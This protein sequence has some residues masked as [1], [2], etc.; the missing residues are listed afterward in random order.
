MDGRAFLSDQGQIA[1]QQ[2]QNAH[3]QSSV[4]DLQNKYNSAQAQNT[5]LQSSMNDLQ[6]QFSSVLAE[7][8][9]LKTIQAECCGSVGS[10]STTGS[11]NLANGSNSDRPSLAQNVPNP[12]TQN[13]IISYYLPASIP[14]A[15]ITIRSMTGTSLQTFNISSAGHGQITVSQGTLAP[16]TYEYDM[17]VN[18]KLIDSK[19]MV[20]IGQ[21]ISSG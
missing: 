16:A 2:T 8:E 14:N 18:G 3:L 19:K 20:I 4:S 13:T 10:T 6:N 11:N 9:Q 15:V 21:S 17:I 12:F 5:Q 7:I 1:A